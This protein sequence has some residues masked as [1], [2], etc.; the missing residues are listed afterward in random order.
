MITRSYGQAHN[1]FA[2]VARQHRGFT[3]FDVRLLVALLEHDGVARTDQLE[4]AMQIEGSAIRRSYCELRAAGFLLAD[5]GEG[6]A[7]PKR[8][9]RARLSLTA[10]GREIAEAA[11]SLATSPLEEAIAA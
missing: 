7:E 11:L 9:T 6:T 8:G 4:A 3:P 1:A 2:M 5:A 10:R